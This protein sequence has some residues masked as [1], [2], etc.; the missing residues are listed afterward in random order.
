MIRAVLFLA[1][2][3]IPL[4]YAL[5]EPPPAAANGEAKKPG[6]PG[7]Q[8]VGYD[9]V[10]QSSGVGRTDASRIDGGPIDRIITRKSGDVRVKQPATKP[11]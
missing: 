3:I 8:H 5:A 9:A 11:K 1:T 6:K 4:S 2:S 7:S 10:E